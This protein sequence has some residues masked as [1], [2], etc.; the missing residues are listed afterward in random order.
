MLCE[1][2]SNKDTFIAS[3]TGNVITGLKNKVT[4]DHLHDYVFVIDICNI[5]NKWMGGDLQNFLHI[6]M[7]LA[8]SLLS[9]KQQQS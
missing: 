5:G 7:D 3:G 1:F 6:T 2:P 4:R 9:L 8:M